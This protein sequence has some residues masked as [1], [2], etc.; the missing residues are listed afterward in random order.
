MYGFQK[1]RRE[2]AQFIFSHPFFLK[3]REDL[4]PLVRRKVK[5]ESRHPLSEEALAE[6]YNSLALARAF[7]KETNNTHFLEVPEASF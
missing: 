4:L 6:H 7:S 2:P 1:S 5:N 3:N